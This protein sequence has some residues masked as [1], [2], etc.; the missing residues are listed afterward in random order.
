MEG[1]YDKESPLRKLMSP[2]NV[3]KD[4]MPLVWKYLTL[5]WQVGLDNF[6]VSIPCFEFSHCHIKDRILQDFD[7]K[8]G[9]ARRIFRKVD[10]TP[11]LA[12]TTSSY[13]RCCDLYGLEDWEDEAWGEV[14][15]P[16]V[17]DD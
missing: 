8:P 11:F 15:G 7:K 13:C 3:V 16:E 14:S 4:V 1:I 17:E 10:P 6:W 5:D 12:D 9:G 2:N